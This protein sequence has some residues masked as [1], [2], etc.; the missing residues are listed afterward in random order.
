MLFTSFLHPGRKIAAL[1]TALGMN[2]IVS[3]RKNGSPP[4]STTT[5]ATSPTPSPP[6]VPFTQVLQTAT[7]LFLTLPLLPS[8]HALFA[9]PEFAATAP[10]TILVNVSRGGIVDETAVLAA[11]KARDRLFGY[12][13]DVFAVE[14]AGGEQDSLLLGEAARGLNVV[15]TAHLAWVSETTLANQKRRVGENLRRFVEGDDGMEDVVV[16]RRRVL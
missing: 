16:P 13:T 14:P 12:A 15:V 9:A 8:T 4:P 10:H 6:R 5:T 2:V 1:C 3:D 7:V 11:L